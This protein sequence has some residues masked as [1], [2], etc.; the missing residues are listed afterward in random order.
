MNKLA[1]PNVG[2]VKYEEFSCLKRKCELSCL[3]VCLSIHLPNYPSMWY[4]GSRLDMCLITKLPPHPELLLM[5]RNQATTQNKEHHSDT[6]TLPKSKHF[7]SKG[8]WKTP[9]IATPRLT[10]LEDLIDKKD[11]GKRL[12]GIASRPD[13]HCLLAIHILPY[14][15]K[16]NASCFLYENHKARIWLNQLNHLFSSGR[17]SSSVQVLDRQ[18]RSWSSGIKRVLISKR[19]N[20]KTQSNGISKIRMHLRERREGTDLTA[21]LQWLNLE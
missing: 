20:T 6:M 7:K 11:D 9:G 21:N 18:I 12:L 3:Y 17:V 2:L 15:I 14:P 4:W 16:G 10:N 13:V 1:Y 5:T 8:S 19:T